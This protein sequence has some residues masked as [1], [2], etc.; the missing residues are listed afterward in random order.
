MVELVNIM[1]QCHISFIP[2]KYF[3]PSHH[4]GLLQQWTKE[5]VSI[6]MV[7]FASNLAYFHFS[8]QSGTLKQP[9]IYNKTNFVKLVSERFYKRFCCMQKVIVT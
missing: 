8:S 2:E 9:Y 5:N 1:S 7:P 3:N 6:Q 4:C